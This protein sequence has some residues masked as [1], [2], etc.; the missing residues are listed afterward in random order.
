MCWV[1]LRRHLNT[2]P[3]MLS[4]ALEVVLCS[5]LESLL[6][7]LYGILGELAGVFAEVDNI[8]VAPRNTARTIIRLLG[9]GVQR[10]GRIADSRYG[11]IQ[12]DLFVYRCVFAVLNDDV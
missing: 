7:F 2:F 1:K 10:D 5:C 9:D 6:V 11:Q 3:K 4:G 8:R 12:D